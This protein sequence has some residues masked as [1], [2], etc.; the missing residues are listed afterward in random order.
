MET[1]RAPEWLEQYRKLSLPSRVLNAIM[2]RV[3]PQYHLFEN[4]EELHSHPLLSIEQQAHYFRL[5]SVTN[6]ARLAHLGLLD[7]RQQALIDGFGREQLRWLCRVPINAL[8]DLRMNNENASFRKR[9]EAVVRNMHESAVEDADRV[10]A[11]L[12]HELTSAIADHEREIY[13]IQ[14]RY[15]RKH[16][17]TAVG[18]WAA[19]GA[20]LIPS[21]APFLG[22]TA[23]LAIASK[24]TWDK[25]EERQEKRVLSK[26]LMGVLAYTKSGKG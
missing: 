26:S 3:S 15:S 22:V 11:E 6:S 25:L 9:M 7:R 4:C 24:Y 21:L 8:V 23:P 1:W 12:S 10:A 19:L 18:A 14:N 20:T 13:E 2:E 5:I 16:G 17:Q